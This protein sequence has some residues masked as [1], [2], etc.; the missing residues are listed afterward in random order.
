MLQLHF[1]RSHPLAPAAGPPLPAGPRP[2]HVIDPLPGACRASLL[3]HPEVGAYVHHTAVPAPEGVAGG[4]MSG[5]SW[6]C[7]MVPS[8]FHEAGRHTEND[9]GSFEDTSGLFS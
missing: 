8:S 4:W 6:I 3:T 1:L 2:E 5:S 7:C 9:D